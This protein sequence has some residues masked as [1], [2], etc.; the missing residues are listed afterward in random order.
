MN[1]RIFQFAL[2]CGWL[3]HH[4]PAPLRSEFKTT[5]LVIWIKLRR[6]WF[7]S[8]AEDWWW[9]NR[10]KEGRTTEGRRSCMELNQC[11]EE[12][13]ISSSNCDDDFCCQGYALHFPRRRLLDSP[14]THSPLPSGVQ[15]ITICIC[16]CHHRQYC[17]CVPLSHGVEFNLISLQEYLQ[18]CRLNYKLGIRP[19][20]YHKLFLHKFGCPALALV[21]TT[22]IGW[23]LCSLVDTFVHF[24]EEIAVLI[25][26][27]RNINWA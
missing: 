17:V 8:I 23:L 21:V 16:R 14:L 25:C 5:K 24:E 12:R 4:P 11:D 13:Y 7:W 15:L 10:K 19:S 18:R 1:L 20:I 27:I 9:W 3:W 22:S 2:L 6:G 26:L